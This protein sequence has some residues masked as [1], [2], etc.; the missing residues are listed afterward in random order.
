M[1]MLAARIGLGL[2]LF[3]LLIV[4][5][6]YALPR[7]VTVE[8]TVVVGRS[9]P[10][11][12]TML[13][14]NRSYRLWAPWWPEKNA[15]EFSYEA[16]DY[17]VGARL[18]WRSGNAG[19]YRTVV[20]VEP[21]HDVKEALSFDS[22][23]EVAGDYILSRHK[24][25]TQVQ[26]RMRIDTRF[27][28]L[29]RWR[30]LFLPKQIGARMEAAL[31]TF[32]SLAQIIPDADIGD[33][34]IQVVTVAARTVAAV[35]LPPP[36]TPDADEAA[37]A[38]ALLRIT[39]YLNERGLYPESQGYKIDIDANTPA[40]QSLGGV[41]IPDGIELPEGSDIG[42]VRT[43][44]GPALLIRVHGGV[45]SIRRVRLRLGSFIQA[46]NMTQVA[47]SWE[48]RTGSAADIYIPVSGTPKDKA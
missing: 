7:F 31:A 44:S 28:I 1:N 36:T 26:W 29:K 25:G 20:A 32:K 33:L 47:P 21:G 30:G 14:S 42:A 40:E 15:P 43:Y 23:G 19:G 11:L 35:T 48:V 5:A 13:A 22:H 38:G 27:D 2:A 17:G 24:G 34:D 6:S 10:I 37:L 8:R 18:V 9:A 39:A 45:D 3:A 4:G 12:Y 46:A 16:A 41:A